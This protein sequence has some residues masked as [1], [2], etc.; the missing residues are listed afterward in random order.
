MRFGVR[1]A[2]EAQ[3]RLASMAREERLKE[4]PESVCGI[5]VSYAGDHGFGAA[6]VLSYP[7]LSILEV[8]VLEGRAPIPYIPTFLA[9][10]E[11]AFLSRLMG[12]MRRE[13]DVFIVDGHGL[14]HPRRCGLATH[15][16]V[17]FNVTS[18]GVAKGRLRMKGLKVVGED[19]VVGG[20]AVGRLV[21]NLYVSVGN[22]IT[23]DE[24]VEIVSRCRRGHSAPE[25]LFLAHRISK[26]LAGC[27][28][29]EE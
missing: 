24:A 26:E 18:I 8:E 25:P 15:F 2:R 16:G 11:M 10:R 12:R 9:F 4:R 27:V 1:R 17:V 6:A 29:I 7:D 14:Y 3:R 20:R 19:V 23:L 28:K 21:G 22:R 5:D 13:P